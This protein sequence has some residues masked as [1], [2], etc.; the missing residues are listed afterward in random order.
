MILYCTGCQKKI[1]PRLTDGKEIYPHRPDLFELPFW[2]CDT[3][4][5]YVG[6]HHKTD[7][8]TTPLGCIPTKEIMKARKHIHAIL[9]PLWR[10]KKIKRTALYDRISE[11]VG[12]HYHT[13]NIRTIDE[14][15]QVYSIALKIKNELEVTND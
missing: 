9:D 12:W 2:K 8:P 4:K 14:A 13:G 3:C 10:N 5:N 1:E 11:V 6:C 15:R 7:H